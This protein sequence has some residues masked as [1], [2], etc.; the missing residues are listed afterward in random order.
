MAPIMTGGSIL[1]A[2]IMTGGSTLMDC[3]FNG[4]YYKWIIHFN[5]WMIHFNPIITGLSILMATI[6]TG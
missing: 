4:C 1:M 6:M 5:C 3:S 2:L